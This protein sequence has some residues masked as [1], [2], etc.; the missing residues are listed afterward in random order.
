MNTRVPARNLV[1]DSLRKHAPHL[2]EEDCRPYPGRHRMPEPDRED[3]R[4]I[5]RPEIPAAEA[6]TRVVATR[7][8]PQPELLR[9]PL[10]SRAGGA[11]LSAARELN[12]APRSSALGRILGY[13][14]RGDQ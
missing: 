11:A 10:P 2:L 9:L 13:L 12:P 8:L 7:P 6:P 4:R 14:K 1:G 5:V 3:A